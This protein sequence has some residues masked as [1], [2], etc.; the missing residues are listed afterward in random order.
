MSLFSN[1]P[2]RDINPVGA[3]L[4][5]SYCRGDVRNAQSISEIQIKGLYLATALM[6]D[7]GRGRTWPNNGNHVSFAQLPNIKSRRLLGSMP[8]DE[9]TLVV[10]VG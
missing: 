7:V 10:S 9:M 8:R 6:S 4:L 2:L 3:M 1:I 5:P